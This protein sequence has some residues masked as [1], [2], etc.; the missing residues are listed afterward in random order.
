MT[1]MT[2]IPGEL[3]R[4]EIEKLVRE[5]LRR[6]GDT[7]GTPRGPFPPMELPIR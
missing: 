2:Q 5:V 1:M 6:Q 4:I 3:G 7:G